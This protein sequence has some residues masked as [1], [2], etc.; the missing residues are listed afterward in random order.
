[1]I[2]K[3]KHGKVKK[4]FE[5]RTLILLQVNGLSKLY[6]A[7]TILA[8]IKL[9]VQTKDRIALVGRNGAGKSTLLKIIAGELS[10]DGGEIIKPKD[11]SIGYLAQNTGL[12]T[13]LTIWDEMLTVFT[14]LRKWR[15]NFEGLSKKW[16]RRKLF[17]R[18]YI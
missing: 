18:S 15:Q 4:L 5:V 16:K 13:S 14:H 9:E 3:Y 8:N 12:E 7:E 6:G 10:H 2:E 1:M 11:V 17:K